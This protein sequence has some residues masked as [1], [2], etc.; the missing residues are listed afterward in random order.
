MKILHCIPTLGGGGAEL[1]L[2]FLCKGL[3]NRGWHVHVGFAGDGQNRRRLE[4]SG[5]TLHQIS[6]SGNY[7]PRILTQLLKIIYS[8]KPDLIQTWIRQMDI[9]GGIAALLTRTPLI[10]TERTSAM[11]YAGRDWRYRARLAIGARA[12]AVVSNSEGGRMYWSQNARPKRNYLIRN[13]LSPEWSSGSRNSRIPSNGDELIVYAGRFSPEKNVLVLTKA[14]IQVL[15]KR[16]N[17]RAVMFGEGILKEE[18]YKVR[19]LSGAGERLSVQPFTAEL[20]KWFRA[21]SF[22]C[23]RVLRR[24]SQYGPRSS[25]LEVSPGSL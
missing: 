15:Q 13:G 21:A 10:V 23:L 3:V 14:L 19:D 7:D 12:A 25:S 5:A 6:T 9:L 11:D 16:P 18:V 1:Q 8:V 22:L 4:D 24:A 2:A 20:P 17:A